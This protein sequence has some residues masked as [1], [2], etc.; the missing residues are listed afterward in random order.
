MT[1]SVR[2]LLTLMLAAALAPALGGCVNQDEYDRTAGTARALEARNLELAQEVQTLEAALAARDRADMALESENQRLRQ[3]REQMMSQMDALAMSI[4]EADAAIRDVSFGGLD[5]GLDR[6]LRRLAASFP[7]LMRY[8]ADQGR[9]AFASDLTFASGSDELRDQAKDGL[10]QLARVLMSSAAQ[11][12]D[13]RIEGHTD[14][15]RP[16][17]PATVR[18]HPTNRHLSAHR[19]ISVARELERDGVDADRLLVAGWGAQRPAVPNNPDGNTPANRRVEVYLVPS[20]RGMT[21]GGAP[22]SSAAPSDAPARS[23]TPRDAPMK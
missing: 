20:T 1:N 23:N 11:G 13:V 19:A 12:Y 10:R 6:D 4:D 3:E 17:N 21:G 2:S 16:S 15:Q 14:S 9:V 18:K 8:D 7:G 22:R 5:P